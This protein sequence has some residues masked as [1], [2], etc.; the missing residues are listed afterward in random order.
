MGKCEL[1]LPSVYPIVWENNKFRINEIDD[2][3]Y[4][5]Y[6]RVQH[7]QHIKEMTDL[8]ESERDELMK[9]VFIVESAIKIYYKPD[10]INL[11]SLGN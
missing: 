4:S 5:A 6:Y 11:A 2:P 3:S 9:V 10:K 8:N 7:I 1:C